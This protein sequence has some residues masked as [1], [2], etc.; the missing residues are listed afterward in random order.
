MELTGRLY[1]KQIGRAVL[2]ILFDQ[3]NN[4]IDAMEPIWDEEDEDFWLSVNRGMPDWSMEPVPETNFHEGAE[5][6]LINAPLE[7]Y[8]SVYVFCHNGTPTNSSDDTG[9]LYAYTL[10]VEM[11]AK[12]GSF[13]EDFDLNLANQATMRLNR[14]QEAAALVMLENRTLNGIVTEIN[15]PSFS[16]GQVFVRR[17]DRGKNPKFYWQGGILRYTVYKWVKML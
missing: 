15:A 10:D 7:Y 2:K 5:P 9:E 13:T 1:D 11:M 8:P 3:L 6:G 17:E 16:K 12:S 14:L 4:K